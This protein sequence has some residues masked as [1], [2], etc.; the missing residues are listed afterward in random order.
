VQGIFNPPIGSG[1]RAQENEEEEKK[2]AGG[3]T[4]LGKYSEQSQTEVNLHAAG[5]NNQQEAVHNGH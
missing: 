2:S 3:D 5:R 1:G 4:E